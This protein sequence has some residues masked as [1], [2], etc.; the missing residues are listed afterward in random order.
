MFSLAQAAQA[1]NDDGTLKDAALSERLVFV[2]KDY[3]SVTA[4]FNAR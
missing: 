3:L 2:L 1:F 4:A